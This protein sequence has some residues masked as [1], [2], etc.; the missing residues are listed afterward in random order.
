MERAHQSSSPATSGDSSNSTEGGGAPVGGDPLAEIDTIL[1]E[2][3]QRDRQSAEYSAHQLDVEQ[4]FLVEFRKACQHE[5][6]PAMEAVLQRLKRNGG[7]GVIE[8]HEGGEPRAPTPRLV[9]WMSLEGE[10]AGEPRADRHPYLQLDA[11]VSKQQVEVSEGTMWHGARGRHSGRIGLE[12][13]R[14]HP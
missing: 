8:A 10:L 7:G 5:V 4:G 2:L 13:H 3:T 6:R 11:E 9:L 12:P 1:A 14:P